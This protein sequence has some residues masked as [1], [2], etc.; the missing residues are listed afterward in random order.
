VRHPGSADVGRAPLRAQWG[1]QQDRCAAVP[2]CGAAVL[3]W[4]A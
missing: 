3:D 2:Q 4:A 1:A